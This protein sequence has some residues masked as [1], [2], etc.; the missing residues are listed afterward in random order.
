[1]PLIGAAYVGV[2]EASAKLAREGVC[3]RRD[4]LT[5]IPAG[6]MENEL[7]PAQLDFESI[8]RL[9]N[10]LDCT[11][12]I[13]NSSAV[14]IRKTLLGQAAITTASKAIEVTGGVTLGMDVEETVR[15]V[16]DVA[17]EPLKY[18]ACSAGNS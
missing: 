4:D 14:L 7:T 1:M 6:S 12:S 17:C 10:A 2:A 8:V 11:P 13:K 9:A 5:A 16:I 18:S 15:Q 3:R